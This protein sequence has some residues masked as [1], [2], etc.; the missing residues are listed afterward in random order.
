[1]LRPFIIVF[2]EKKIISQL[3]ADKAFKKLYFRYL[4][5]KQS[6]FFLR[7]SAIQKKIP[8]R[9]S[10]AHITGSVMVSLWQTVQEYWIRQK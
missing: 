9:E 8:Q 10:F 3:S 7:K 4:I 1:M 5:K 2:L 6:S